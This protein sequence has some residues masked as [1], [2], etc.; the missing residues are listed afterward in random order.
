MLWTVPVRQAYCQQKLFEN[1]KEWYRIYHVRKLHAKYELQET[2]DEIM[3]MSM[4]K[5]KSI[6]KGRVASFAT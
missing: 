5:W 2:E 3:T 4:E 6:V 1:E